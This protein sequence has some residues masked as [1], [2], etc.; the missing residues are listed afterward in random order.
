[1]IP[2]EE[3]DRLIKDNQTYQKMTN[4]LIDL[5]NKYK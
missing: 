3:L 4:E 2:V 5:I 1:M